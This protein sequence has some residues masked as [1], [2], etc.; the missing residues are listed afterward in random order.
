M[1]DFPVSAPQTEQER[2]PSRVALSPWTMSTHY[3]ADALAGVHVLRLAPGDAA[4]GVER[5]VL[6]G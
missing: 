3:S 6:R 2:P 5:A 1:R 4:V